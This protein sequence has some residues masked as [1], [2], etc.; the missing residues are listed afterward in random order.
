MRVHPRVSVHACPRVSTSV[1]AFSP[2]DRPVFP[3]GSHVHGV[4]MAWIWRIHVCTC[5]WGENRAILGEIQPTHG[6]TWMAMLGH[7]RRRVCPRVS[8]HVHTCPRVSTRVHACACVST[9]VHAC[10]RVSMTGNACA[11]VSAFFPQDRP[12]FPPGRRVHGVYMA[13]IWRIHVCTC[14]WGKNRAILGEIQPTPRW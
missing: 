8:T 7:A 9:R 1:S 4:N 14:F 13:W 6:Q 10:P 11:C 2:Q 3:P 5:F 12:V